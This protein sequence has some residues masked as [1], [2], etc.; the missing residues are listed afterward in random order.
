MILHEPSF[1][2][3]TCSKES[4]DVKVQNAA[5]WTDAGAK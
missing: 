3:V 1:A 2:A 4:R 5:L